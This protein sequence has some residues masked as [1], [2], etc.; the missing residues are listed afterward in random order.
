[1][2]GGGMV[3]LAEEWRTVPP[4]TSCDITNSTLSREVGGWLAGGGEVI[5]IQFD[6]RS[7]H[8]Q[9]LEHVQV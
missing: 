9:E 5:Q 8:I 1:M 3:E 7:C 4:S 2:N 6:A